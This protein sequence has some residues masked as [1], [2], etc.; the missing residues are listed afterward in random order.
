MYKPSR[1]GALPTTTRF[2]AA[3]PHAPRRQNTTNG[4]RR[5]TANTTGDDPHAPYAPR[6]KPPPIL[7]ITRRNVFLQHTAPLRLTFTLALLI[8][9]SNAIPPPHIH[10]HRIARSHIIHLVHSLQMHTR[11]LH[12]QRKGSLPHPPRH[13]QRRTRLQTLRRLDEMVIPVFAHRTVYA[14]ADTYSRT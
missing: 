12:L 2:V 9:I 13:I 3:A 10:T 5:P 14:R 8:F 1:P 4:P 11:Q 6:R 7:S